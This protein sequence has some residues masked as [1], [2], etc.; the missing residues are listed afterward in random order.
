MSPLNQLATGDSTRFLVA[1]SPQTSGGAIS[2]NIGEPERAADDK[3]GIQMT[4]ASARRPTK[5]SPRGVASPRTNAL[6]SLLPAPWPVRGRP[7]LVASDTGQEMRF[8][9]P[10]VGIDISCRPSSGT[11]VKAMIEKMF[12]D[13]KPQPLRRCKKA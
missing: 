6:S 11:S 2:K 5:N 10:E 8:G 4:K 9:P 13:F 12:S 1:G 7:H 3:D